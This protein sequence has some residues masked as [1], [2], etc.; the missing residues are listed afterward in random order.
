MFNNFDILTDTYAK[1]MDDLFNSSL[2]INAT[3]NIS[4]EDVGQEST[5]VSSSNQLD[6]RGIQKIKVNYPQGLNRYYRIRVFPLEPSGVKSGNSDISYDRGTQ[7]V[8]YDRWVS[9]FISTVSIG[10]NTTYFDYASDVTI[11]NITYKIKGVVKETF[12]KP[13]IHVFLVKESS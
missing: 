1:I 5:Y 7:F 4:G 8:P 2:T 13:V 11:G 6:T 10:N 9:C 12:G 3:I